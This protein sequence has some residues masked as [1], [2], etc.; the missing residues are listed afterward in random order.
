MT[1]HQHFRSLRTTAACVAGALLLAGPGVAAAADEQ[2]WEPARGE[3]IVPAGPGGGLD[4]AARML[5]HLLQ[6]QGFY[7]DLVVA[8]R[9][10]GSMAIAFNELDAHPGNGSYVMTSTSSIMNYQI[11]GALD[12]KLSDYTQIATLFDEYV[13]V[14]VRADSPYKTAQD[15]IDKFKESPGEL[16]IGVA[17]S[18]GNHIHVGIASP[19]KEAGVDISKLTIVPYKSSTESMTALIGGHLDVVSATTPNLIGPM[20]ANAI[21]VLAVGAPE[22]LSAPLE[23]IPTWIEEGIN[24]VPSSSQGIHGPKNMPQE[25]VEAWATALDKA[26]ASQ[27]WKDLLAKNH[28]REHYLGPKETEK[29]RAEEY[30]KIHTILSELG[31]VKN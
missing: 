8:N 5:S 2:P 19:L 13:A 20:Q 24:V 30:N 26:V 10:G 15:L 7:S 6:Q 9:P 22:R 29:F 17:T 4:T 1:L 18:I 21:R 23:G 12:R 27:Q 11:L 14:A 25:Q 16:N 28:W 3:F 31:L